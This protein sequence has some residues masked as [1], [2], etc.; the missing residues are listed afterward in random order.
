MLMGEDEAEGED[1]SFDGSHSHLKLAE[2]LSKLE[3]NQ[4]PE[5][6]EK[7]ENPPQAKEESPFR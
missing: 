5:L 6:I 1:G 4:Q 3:I 2:Q 7:K